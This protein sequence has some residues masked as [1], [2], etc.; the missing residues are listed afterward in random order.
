MNS[1]EKRLIIE[2]QY[3]EGCPNA[4]ATLENLLEA[5]NE[6]GLPEE[7]IKVVKIDDLASARMHKF[8]G[9]PT[10]LING[11]D[12]Y[13]ERE[14]QGFNFT[15]RIYNFDGEQTGKIPKEYVKEKILAYFSSQ[16]TE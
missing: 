2:F 9:S 10:I 3:F 11:R 8:Q 1:A 12:I 14:P 6:L 16:A 5:I 4:G 15:C 7:I 13:T